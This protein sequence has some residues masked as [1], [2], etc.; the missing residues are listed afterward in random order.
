MDKLSSIVFISISVGLVVH[1]SLFKDI[2]LVVEDLHKLNNAI[3][4]CLI[5]LNIILDAR[6]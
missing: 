3:N 6:R 4:T 1:G 2:H 5:N